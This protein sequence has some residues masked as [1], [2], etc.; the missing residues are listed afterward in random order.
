MKYLLLCLYLSFPFVSKAQIDQI[1]GMIANLSNELEVQKSI[2]SGLY[3]EKIKLLGIVQKNKKIN[4]KTQN[5][6]TETNISLYNLRGTLKKMQ[7]DKSLLTY[8]IEQLKR[9]NAEK[10][11]LLESSTNLNEGIV[12][13][14]SAAKATINNLEAEL[15]RKN[16]K[17][18]VWDA[19]KR[20]DQEYQNTVNYDT[21]VIKDVEKWQPSDSDSP[22]TIKFTAIFNAGFVGTD[23][24]GYAFNL[25]P[26]I[27]YKNNLFIG[28]GI[29]QE[30]Y[31]N[32]REFSTTLVNIN[33][34]AS[35]S[36]YGIAY[37]DEVSFLNN[38]YCNIEFG[39]A[40]LQDKSPSIS[41]NSGTNLNF[42]FGMFYFFNENVSF[43]TNV[44]YK[45]QQYSVVNGKGDIDGICMKIGVIYK[46]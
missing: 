5:D 12:N 31:P 38:V 7:G 24:Y 28:L 34:K 3:T 26:G 35:F 2:A 11:R 46:F 14:L 6:L 17:Q 36:K 44:G 10:A 33:I 42:G 32:Y 40:F 18:V 45:L 39:K 41:S 29:G 4:K 23:N 16:Q 43:D 21:E 20:Y 8:K 13:E 37:S 22:Q 19:K 1:R 9:D 30:N 25:Y 27:V 15:E